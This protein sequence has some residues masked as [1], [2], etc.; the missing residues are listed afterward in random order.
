MNIIASE[1]PVPPIL[2]N[3]NY[4][5]EG[6]MD[7]RGRSHPPQCTTSREDRQLVR[8]AAMNRSVISRTLAQHIEFVAHHSV[9]ERT[10][11]RR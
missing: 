2:S 4:D 5:Y 1:I 8:M 11:R 10:I 6:T 7:R 9:S 3:Q